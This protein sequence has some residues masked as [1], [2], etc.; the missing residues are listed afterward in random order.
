MAVG[1]QRSHGKLI[2]HH[3]HC[4]VQILCSYYDIFDPEEQISS[5]LG[6]E[7]RSTTQ[8]MQ[9]T[10]AETEYMINNNLKQWRSSK[11]KCTEVCN[12]SDHIC[13]KRNLSNKIV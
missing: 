13:H 11:Y 1:F 5:F 2:L 9:V 12:N 6:I 8:K 10:D 3:I 4:A 7:F